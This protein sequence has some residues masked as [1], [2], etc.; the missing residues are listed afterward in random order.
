MTHLRGCLRQSSDYTRGLERIAKGQ[1]A[2][3][4]LEARAGIAQVV[5][6]TR[7]LYGGR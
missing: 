3:N 2:S 5:V 6:S 1:G 4:R 7:R